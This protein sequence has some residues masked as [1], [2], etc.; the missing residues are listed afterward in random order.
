M[1]FT[2]ATIVIGVPTGIKI[3]SWLSMLLNRQVNVEGVLVWVYGFLVLFTVGRVTGITLSN[4]SIDL[5][6][7]DTYFVVAHFHYVLSMSAVYG[8]ILGFCQYQNIFLRSVSSNLMYE[9]YFFLLFIGVNMVF[10]PIH[11]L[12]LSGMPRRYYVYNDMLQ[13]V[14]IFIFAG[15]ILLI[16]S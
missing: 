1:Y 3:F 11:Q 6:L 9:L 4:N 7:H 10:F 16:T 12:G 13:K 2:A 5:I 15:V 14:N 8:T